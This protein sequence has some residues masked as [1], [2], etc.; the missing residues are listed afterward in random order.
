MNNGKLPMQPIYIDDEGVARFRLNRIVR[1][2]VNLHNGGL[3][4]LQRELIGLAEREDWEQLAQLIGYSVSGFGDL[5]YA[6]PEAVAAADAEAQR[7]VSAQAKE[8]K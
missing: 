7:V 2:L 8:K 5:D 1:Y 6:S 3:N 4:G